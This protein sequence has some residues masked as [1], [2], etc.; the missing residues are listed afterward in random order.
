MIFFHSFTDSD[1]YLLLSFQNW[2][3]TIQEEE[4]QRKLFVCLFIKNASKNT[5]Y[6]LFLILALTFCILA[7]VPVGLDWCQFGQTKPSRIL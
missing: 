1:S 3:I 4:I 2:S 5:I 6:T 7:D